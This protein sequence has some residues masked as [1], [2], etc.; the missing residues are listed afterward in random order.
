MKFKTKH[1]S[2]NLS[3]LSFKMSS[4][5]V[6]V[7]FCKKKFLWLTISLTNQFSEKRAFVRDAKV[8]LNTWA[9][10]TLTTA[11]QIDLINSISSWCSMKFKW[12]CKRIQILVVFSLGNN[13][14]GDWHLTED[15]PQKDTDHFLLA[16]V[17]DNTFTEWFLWCNR[18]GRFSRWWGGCFSCCWL[19]SIHVS[20]W[21]IK[22]NYIIYTIFSFLK[23]L[24]HFRSLVITSVYKIK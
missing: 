13:L 9:L 22:I 17:K 5:V 19:F 18:C 12:F 10:T 4:S 23:I 8:K 6:K 1:C 14:S 21:I 24:K 16:L 15:I 3:F 2:Y 7:P 11:H 20:L